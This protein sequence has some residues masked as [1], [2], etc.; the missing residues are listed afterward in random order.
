MYHLI[1]ETLALI[2]YLLPQKNA[3]NNYI[4][5]LVTVTVICLSGTKKILLRKYSFF[6]NITGVKLKAMTIYIMQTKMLQV[7][8]IGC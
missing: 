3:M 2:F 8:I 4:T 6:V 1:Y 5:Y 7:R